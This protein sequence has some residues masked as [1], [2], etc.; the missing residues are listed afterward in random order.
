M[1]GSRLATMS[2]IGNFFCSMGRLNFSSNWSIF[3]TLFG[4]SVKL[5]IQ[6][7]LF[8]L[9][10]VKKIKNLL[11]ELTL[12]DMEPSSLLRKMKELSCGKF[13]DELLKT[14]WLQ[15]LPINVPAIL[16][17]S[18]ENLDQL[19]VMADA[20]LD[21]I[22]FPAVQSVSA[23]HSN[24]STSQNKIDDLVNAV[25]QL[26]G[27][28]ERLSRDYRKPG[29]SNGQSSRHRTQ[30]LLRHRLFQKIIC[31]IITKS[32]TQRLSSV[33]N[34]VISKVRSRKTRTPVKFSD[35]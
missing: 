18:T 29:Q 13:N 22:E 19:T 2:M 9:F 3:L 26:E 31:A 16:S 15:I 30:R 25:C 33:G 23:D 8:L 28:I 10:V 34:L 11:H 32:L 35:V 20:M 24:L 27:K 14:L 6:P 21:I 5:I 17:I 4:T 7:P 1:V 12:G